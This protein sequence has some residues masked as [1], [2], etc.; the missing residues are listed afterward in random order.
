MS[1][2]QDLKRI[3]KEKETVVSE[4]NASFCKKLLIRDLEQLQ[5]QDSR[6][7]AQGSGK[8]TFEKLIISVRKEGVLDIEDRRG[9]AF[10]WSFE[11]QH[12]NEF[13]IGDIF[14][15]NN[16]PESVTYVNESDDPILLDEVKKVIE[17]FDKSIALL[18]TAIPLETWTY[19]YY[20]CHEEQICENLNDV[21]QTVLSREY[22]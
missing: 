20:D 1:E 3:S 12:E 15:Y 7:V 2:L 13:R 16:R 11:I 9:S 8:Y 19:K 17:G 10:L 4:L 21:I 22:Q 6:L 18:R 5:K 14:L